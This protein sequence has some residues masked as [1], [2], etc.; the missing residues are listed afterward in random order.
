MT[1]NKYPNFDVLKF[2]RWYKTIKVT[3]S[4]LKQEGPLKKT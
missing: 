1:V 2:C 3:I 4:F